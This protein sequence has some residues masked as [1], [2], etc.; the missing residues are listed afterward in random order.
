VFYYFF[1]DDV[2]LLLVEVFFFRARGWSVGSLFFILVFLL[3]SSC[4]L[5]GEFVSSQ[6]F[7]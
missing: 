1:Y 3:L 6:N 4:F 7:V 5:L 2:G